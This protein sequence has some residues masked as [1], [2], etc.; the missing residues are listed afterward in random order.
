MIGLQTIPTSYRSELA[1]AIRRVNAEH[2]A[3]GRPDLPELNGC[4]VDLM[5]QIQVATSA[6]D[7]VVELK[8]I[9]SW[10]TEAIDL[11]R[12]SR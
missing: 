11:I 1:A 4:W 6:G 5:T 2:D 10:E 8:A 12:R 9:R 3:A 7:D